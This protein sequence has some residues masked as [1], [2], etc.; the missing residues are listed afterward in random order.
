MIQQHKAM[1]THDYPIQLAINFHQRSMNVQLLD[2]LYPS[3]YSMILLLV[4]NLFSKD[5]VLSGKFLIH[6]P[7]I[8]C[9]EM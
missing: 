6:N 8:F 1:E 4:F 7:G 5:S 9:N 2:M 3:Y